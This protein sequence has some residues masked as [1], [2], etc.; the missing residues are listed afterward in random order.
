MQLRRRDVKDSNLSKLET[1]RAA[2][3]SQQRKNRQAILARIRSLASDSP[4]RNTTEANLSPTKMIK[5]PLVPKL[6]DETKNEMETDVSFRNI[7]DNK[8]EKRRRKRRIEYGRMLMQPEWLVEIPSD[9]SDEWRVMA[10]P[11]GKRCMVSSRDCFT[12]ARSRDGEVMFKFNSSLPGGSRARTGGNSCS[13]IDCIYNEDTKTFYV[14]DVLKWNYL[15]FHEHDIEFRSC[16]VSMKIEENREPIS[17]TNEY[18]FQCPSLHPCDSD[19][20]RLCYEEDSYPVDGL[21][22]FHTETLYNCGL[23][24]LVLLWKDSKCSKWH[25]NSDNGSSPNPELTCSLRVTN[26]RLLVT[27]DDVSI[28]KLERALELQPN[29]LVKYAIHGIDSAAQTV[30]STRFIGK[31]SLRKIF[32]D[33]WSKLLFQHQARNRLSVTYEQLASALKDQKASSSFSVS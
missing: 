18:L 22:F 30:S 16:W 20:L 32:P 27:R 33:S 31:C 17:K 21:L 4:P 1:R 19:K 23:T 15:D 25:I 5:D 10:R 2:F 29:D 6:T 7:K 24:P 26:K 8:R 9:L 14:I 28:G 13:V 3:I 11:E 12:T